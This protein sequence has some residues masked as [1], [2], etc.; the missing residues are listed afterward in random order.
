M[1]RS[2]T[3]LLLFPLAVAAQPAGKL[4]GRVVDGSGNPLPGANV[5]IEGPWHS[6]STDVDGRYLLGAPPG[7]YAVA[8]SHIAHEPRTDIVIIEPG[9]T[10]RHDIVLPL[11]PGCKPDSSYRAEDFSWQETWLPTTRTIA[12]AHGLEPLHGRS[13]GLREARLWAVSPTDLGDPWNM[14]RVVW[15]DVEGEVVLGWPIRLRSYSARMEP[16]GIEESLDKLYRSR[17]SSQCG[18][19]RQG[20]SVDTCTPELTEEPDWTSVA[21]GLEDAGLWTL[22]DETAL[23]DLYAPCGFPSSGRD[24]TTYIVELFDGSSYRTYHYWSPDAN[25]S[26]PE[27]RQAAR[28]ARIVWND[29]LDLI[30]Q[31]EY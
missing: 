24:G 2:L 21:R 15:N 18:P 10:T 22:P 29:V 1:M 27:E 23:P 7:R 30:P 17:W 19:F 28:I 11:V 13:S 5:T 31:T 16:E 6:T 20:A 9:S 4:A 3:L 25:A 26:W 14:V 8:A 12:D